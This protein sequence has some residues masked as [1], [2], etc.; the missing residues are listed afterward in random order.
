[1]GAMA[2]QQGTLVRFTRK[3]YRM[4]RKVSTDPNDSHERDER[5]V[6]WQ[7][8]DE[9]TKRVIEKSD[10]DLR[11]MYVARELDFARDD[12]KRSD[13]KRGGDRTDFGK[14]YLDVPEKRF[15]RA[16]LK[17]TY[18]LAVMGL[19]TT[20]DTIMNT[21]QETWL[22]LDKQPPVAPHW[23]TV[24]RWRKQLINAGLDVHAVVDK[25]DKR[26]N[27]TER[28]PEKVIEIAEQAID[29]VY[30]Q[31]ER[32]TIQDTVDK[33]QHEVNL[34][35]TN[36]VEGFKL[37]SPTRRLIER[38][39]G[40]IPAFDIC[41]SRYG[42]TVAAK[43]FRSVLGHRTTEAPLQR[44]EID[45]TLMDL[46]VIDDDSGLPLGRPVLTACIDDYSRCVLGINIGFEPA[47]FLTVARCLKN[48]FMP[49][50]NL[51]ALYPKVQNDWDAHGVM[52]ELSMDN[53][54]EFHSNS[55]EEGCYSLGIEIHYSPRKSPW[56]KGKIERYLG[57]MN[58]EVAHIAPGTTFSNIFEK[59]DYDPA[60]HAVVRLS[61]LQHVARI[62]ICDVYHQR[63]H[64]T[65][66]VPPVQMWKSGINV[67]DILLP[68]DPERLDAILGRREQRVLTHKGIEFEGLLYNSPDMTTLRMRHGEKLDV[69]IS[70]DDGDI[71]KVVVLSPDKKRMFV[72]PA[73]AQTYAKGLTAWQHKVCKRYA[74]REW[75]K[76]DSSAWLKAKETIAEMIRA[77]MS[78]KKGKN[79]K[80]KP[81]NR[82]GRW[83]EGKSL[84]PAP[85]SPASAPAPAPAPAPA[86]PPPPAAAQPASA[87]EA[88]RFG[89]VMRSRT[90]PTNP[91]SS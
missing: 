89:H 3:V 64:R 74:A 51:K 10:S 73:L 1:M 63:P 25:V 55:L 61:T 76:Y 19:S 65:L 38:L 88:P 13:E 58:A 8:E 81:R 6:V 33:A 72:V 59:D 78:H 36:R 23:T 62:W 52:R 57:T 75:E 11:L 69:E 26:G 37:P 40:K 47:S 66:K 39:I 80:N 20:K 2:F 48:A 84:P 17:R 18:A 83:T 35:N 60:K 90:P 56:C 45:H 70:I 5:D 32:K 42:R 30:L 21:V 50:T 16:K 27:R 91:T 54:L 46:M 12:E 85:P 79:K 82:M 22:K 4:V 53:G 34:E 86:L 31:R 28:Y 43:R 7:L 9:K 68:E 15:D 14:P 44:A 71:G 77:E 41:V 29:T 67:E 24:Y 49:K 87:P